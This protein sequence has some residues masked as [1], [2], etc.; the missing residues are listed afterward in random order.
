MDEIIEYVL[1]SVLDGVGTVKLGDQKAFICPYPS[2]NLEKKTVSCVVPICV[3]K[4]P[5]PKTKG[6][7]RVQDIDY[8][9]SVL[10]IPTKEDI[11]YLEKVVTYCKKI[12]DTGENLISQYEMPPEETKSP[13]L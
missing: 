3:L 7:I 10:I 4:E 6:L 8:V 2:I 11:D 5:H 9:A 13:S 12:F 1:D